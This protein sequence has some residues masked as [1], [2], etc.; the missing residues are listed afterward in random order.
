M[1]VVADRLGIPTGKVLKVHVYKYQVPCANKEYVSS[2]HPSN[3]ACVQ[4]VVTKKPSSVHDMTNASLSFWRGLEEV[5]DSVGLS[6]IDLLRLYLFLCQGGTAE[7]AAEDMLGKRPHKMT[8]L[9]F[10]QVRNAQSYQPN[11]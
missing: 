1:F 9:K 5:Q 4:T 3:V 6:H 7:Q 11:H 2:T 8:C 10:K